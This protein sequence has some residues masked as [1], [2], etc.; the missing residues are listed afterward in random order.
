MTAASVPRHGQDAASPPRSPGSLSASRSRSLSP[1]SQASRA[2]PLGAATGPVA[3]PASASSEES[4][5]G[6]PA[7][8]SSSASAAAASGSVPPAHGALPVASPR[9]AAAAAALR[10]FRATGT[11]SRVQV[12][13]SKR[14]V[15][16]I[17]EAAAPPECDAQPA[18][19][20][21]KLYTMLLIYK[22]AAFQQQA[23][24]RAK[25][26]QGAES[27]AVAEPHMALLGNAPDGVEEVERDRLLRALKELCEEMHDPLELAVR[28]AHGLVGLLPLAQGC[29]LCVIT[30]AAKVASFLG[31][32]DIFRVAETKMV[33]VFTAAPIPPNFP[34][35]VH[36]A[37]C[38]APAAPQPPLP[39]GTPRTRTACVCG[40]HFSASSHEECHPPR[41]DSGSSRGG[42]PL[43]SSPQ[44]PASCSLPALPPLRSA[45]RDAKSPAVPSTWSAAARAADNKYESLLASFAPEKSCFFCRSFFL[46]LPLQQ[47]AARSCRASS[48][49]KERVFGGGSEAAAHTQA[50]ETDEAAE[51]NN[52]ISFHDF[53]ACCDSE[54]DAREIPLRKEERR[55]IW[56]YAL[57]EAFFRQGAAGAACV[58]RG[59]LLP[60]LHGF[61]RPV[62]LSL[63][64]G[65]AQLLLIARRSAF[66]AGTRYRK[67]GLSVAGDSANEVETEFIFYT[68][69]P[70][71]HPSA[72]PLTCPPRAPPSPL[73]SADSGWPR[74]FDFHLF[75][76]VQV[77]GSAPTFWAQAA[78]VLPAMPPIVCAQTDVN[79]SATRRHFSSLFQRYGAPIHCLNLLQR[80]RPP[81][82]A[83]SLAAAPAPLS[84]Q[85]TLLAAGD[86]ARLESFGARPET[87]G[88]EPLGALPATSWLSRA[89]SLELAS[90]LAAPSSASCE[91]STLASQTSGPLHASVV[92]A[93]LAAGRKGTGYESREEQENALGEVYRQLVEALNEELPPSLRLE[94]HWID[95]KRQHAPVQAA[96]AALS[97]RAP[98]VSSAPPW[99]LQANPLHAD[100]VACGDLVAHAENLRR[101]RDASRAGEALPGFFESLTAAC[102]DAK[103]ADETRRLARARA[104]QEAL[105][106]PYQRLKLLSEEMRDTVGFFYTN[107]PVTLRA[108]RIQHGVCRINCLDCLDR[109]NDAQLSL[110]HALLLHF[111]RAM[112]FVPADTTELDLPIA[113]TLAGLLEAAGDEIAMQYGGSNAHK[114]QRR[115][116]SCPSSPPPSLP[117]ATSAP[118]PPSPSPAASA[119]ASRAAPAPVPPA[120]ALSA[121]VL[122][123][124]SALARAAPL[125]SS[126]PAASSACIRVSLLREGEARAPSGIASWL[127][128]ASTAIFGFSRGGRPEGDEG[129][130]EGP[131]AE[132]TGLLSSPL[133]LLSL[134]T[135]VKRRY[136]NVLAD[137]G[138]QQAVNLFQCRFRPADVLEGNAFELAPASQEADADVWCHHE[139]LAPAFEPGDWWVLPLQRFVNAMRLAL[140]A[141]TLS[142]VAPLPACAGAALSP[143]SP[144]PPS[145]APGCAL[146]SSFCPLCV[147]SP[148]AW[149]PAESAVTAAPLPP[150]RAAA[151]PRWLALFGGP[152]ERL[153]LPPSLRVPRVAAG[154]PS[155]A[156]RLRLSPDELRFAP[157]CCACAAPSSPRA[158]L[159]ASEDARENRALGRRAS[160]ADGLDGGLGCVF[161]YRPWIEEAKAEG[162][163]AA[164]LVSRV[165][166]REAAEDAEAEENTPSEGGGCRDASSVGESCEEVSLFQ[167][168]FALLLPAC[169]VR[170]TAAQ[171][172]PRGCRRA[173]VGAAASAPR[174]PAVATPA[175]VVRGD[176]AASS[177]GADG[178]PATAADQRQ[179]TARREPLAAVATSASPRGSSPSVADACW[180]AGRAQAAALPSRICLSPRPS[181]PPPAAPAHRYRALQELAADDKLDGERALFARFLEE[182]PAGGG[183][184]RAAVLRA[185]ET[186]S[187]ASEM[188]PAESASEDAEPCGDGGRGAGRRAARDE[189]EGRPPG[190]M[191]TPDRP[192]LPLDT[193]A[194]GALGA[195]RSQG[196]GER[197][198]DLRR[199]AREARAFHFRIGDAPSLG[200]FLLASHPSSLLAP[201]RPSAFT[202]LQTFHAFEASLLC[203]R[204]ALAVA[205]RSGRIEC[206]CASG[207][208]RGA[209]VAPCPRA[210]AAAGPDSR[211]D[212][213]EA[214]AS[215]RR[216]QPRHTAGC[217]PET[218]GSRDGAAASRAPCASPFCLFYGGLSVSQALAALDAEA[219]PRG[220]ARPELRAG[221]SLVARSLSHELENGRKRLG[222]RGAEKAATAPHELFGRRGAAAEAWM[223]PRKGRLPPPDLFFASDRLVRRGTG[224]FESS[225]DAF[226]PPLSQ[227]AEVEGLESELAVEA[228]LAAAAS[229]ADLALSAPL[230]S[231]FA[232][233][234]GRACA[235]DAAGARLFFS[236]VD[237]PLASSKE[238]GCGD[239]STRSPL[240][241]PERS[242]APATG[243][244]GSAGAEGDLRPR[245]LSPASDSSRAQIEEGDAPWRLFGKDVERKKDE[246]A[247]F[248]AQAENAFSL[249]CD[250]GSVCFASYRAAE[251]A[252][253]SVSSAS[254]PAVRCARPFAVVF[255]SS[256]L[257]A[258]DGDFSLDVP[259]CGIDWRLFASSPW[260]NLCVVVGSFR[261]PQFRCPR[262]RASLLS[263]FALIAVCSSL[264]VSALLRGPAAPSPALLAAGF[265]GVSSY[266]SPFP[267]ASVLAAS[268]AR[269]APLASSPH[270]LAAI[271]PFSPSAAASPLARAPAQSP[272]ADERFPPSASIFSAPASV[273]WRLLS[274]PF[275][276][277]VAL[278]TPAV[279]AA[280]PGD[281]DGQGSWST[282]ALGDSGD[283]SWRS[284]AHGAFLIVKRQVAQQVRTHRPELRRLVQGLMQMF[285]QCFRSFFGV[286]ILGLSVLV[287]P[288]CASSATRFETEVNRVPLNDPYLLSQLDLPEDASPSLFGMPYYDVALA[289]PPAAW[290]SLLN[291]QGHSD[292]RVAHDDS[293]GRSEKPRG[294]EAP[295]GSCAGDGADAPQRCAD[296]ELQA[297]DA[298]RFNDQEAAAKDGGEQECTRRE[299]DRRPLYGEAEGEAARADVL[300]GWWIPAEDRNSKKAIICAHGWLANRQACLPFLGVAKKIGLHADHNV[301]LLDMKNS[302]ESSS[303]ATAFGAGCSPE[304]PGGRCD[305]GS[306]F[307]LGASVK[308]KAKTGDALLGCQAA[309]DLLQAILWMKKTHGISSVSIYAQGV[310]AMGTMLLVG[311]YR[312]QLES[313]LGV[314]IDRVVFDSPICNARDAIESQPLTACIARTAQWLHDVLMWAV[315]QRRGQEL[316]RMRASL[317]LPALRP[318]KKLVLTSQEDEL[319]PWSSVRK[320]LMLLPEADRPEWTY[321]FP[322]GAH[323]DVIRANPEAS[324]AVLK[325]FYSEPSFLG[326]LWETIVGKRAA[327]SA[328]SGVQA[329]DPEDFTICLERQEIEEEQRQKELDKA[330]EPESRAKVGR[331]KLAIAAAASVLDALSF[332]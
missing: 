182:Q 95:L 203:P 250:G 3:F 255:H 308:A 205:E 136:H 18:P 41:C 258:G 117:V 134:A 280:E 168:S 311:R 312:E 160:A 300:K 11:V 323:C 216:P 44:S 64:R 307:P 186:S 131:N 222:S 4:S 91:A 66:F 326:R 209:W 296:S 242:C 197:S 70:R 238:G 56:N 246:Y 320:E 183:A 43:P 294:T 9:L 256:S 78:T 240:S 283:A 306:G 261:T 185:A 107:D 90:A 27:P 93:A 30:Q 303:P 60:L 235:G 324:S 104:A 149:V 166:P 332:L 144:P 114:K 61:V 146:A 51:T 65:T 210:C 119:A 125:H 59:L 292:A 198:E 174:R 40:M 330:R 94:F 135:S 13:E 156:F 259:L 221:T 207:T 211:R 319:A 81:P 187:S 193:A 325:A 249:V 201:S 214:V 138:K 71:A 290:L 15:L 24:E 313:S 190:R 118:R 220:A 298:W 7:S 10:S 305:W 231:A 328:G 181:T 165:L 109:T 268:G 77:R 316:R 219:V 317:L 253:L 194:A 178:A 171:A 57:M 224:V 244:R 153:A 170:R 172:R 245:L 73:V 159:V 100:L 288:F 79:R 1:S 26:L 196:S 215:G 54:A 129:G 241:P 277:S 12:F 289:P 218:G 262:S 329:L 301:L 48:P 248:L 76:H 223:E 128:R 63:A 46:C 68:Y 58:R 295:R 31:V 23:A 132:E 97:P 287:L 98:Q 83:P 273:L 157:A 212:A 37:L 140:A 80:R 133:F 278:R 247:E 158:S 8:S 252:C 155:P 167:A 151:C 82:P 179:R 284:R 267:S 147:R 124:S 113:S 270:W 5:C 50:P 293:T 281:S 152:L 239:A 266:S 75:S 6:F 42:D 285:F 154:P 176:A 291:E 189:G 17:G 230:A 20:H 137:G 202:T 148:R 55:F 260:Q 263:L 141:K 163:H 36:Q 112:R 192:R 87:A 121:S 72:G 14:L 177:P 38:S 29:R 225:A 116:R 35:Y 53:L 96:A 274:K 164:E 322:S 34:V 310:S 302:G 234:V 92:D 314:K 213:A 88:S 28:D 233:Q 89:A 69:T 25:G 105:L 99:G 199:R 45:L 33:P 315:N 206:L 318:V 49:T 47:V 236:P 271:P 228:S 2:S 229:G 130:Q 321:L 21:H 286:Y 67:R 175:H 297:T 122:S 127:D 188:T 84:R 331:K 32:H 145:S 110:H 123:A 327:V 52:E 217:L 173:T 62:S 126:S 200:G 279:A 180:R 19:A 106:T 304:G 264:H 184:A 85:T 111:L 254:V 208:C 101:R 86:A 269:P 161:T 265:D 237:W 226:L 103:A 282:V 243:R 272:L 139:W 102:G 120:T 309:R 191:Q 227:I 299:M 162:V 108:T 143:P 257:E 204:C 276:P 169:F 195:E 39:P 251:V 275:A 232:P 16:L 142:A 150:R 115:L 74:V 22:H